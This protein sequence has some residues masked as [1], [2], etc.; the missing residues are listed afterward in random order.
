MLHGLWTNGFAEDCHVKE[1]RKRVENG[2]TTT[3]K[4]LS[5]PAE[6]RKN[7]VVRGKQ[8]RPH[9]QPRRGGG[10][11]RRFRVHVFRV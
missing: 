1:I 11:K 2:P 8:N 4:S 9:P 6:A 5:I 3:I 7:E 10:R